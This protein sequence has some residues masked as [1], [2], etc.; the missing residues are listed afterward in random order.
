[1]LTAQWYS[2]KEPKSCASITGFNIQEQEG[3]TKLNDY[4][5]TEA[6]TFWD[7]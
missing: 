6:K 3:K 4:Q 5:I 7:Y 2:V 1:M